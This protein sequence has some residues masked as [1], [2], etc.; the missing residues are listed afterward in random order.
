MGV[1]PSAG[2]ILSPDHAAALPP[3]PA[4]DALLKARLK[5][6]SAKAHKR[7]KDTTEEDRE[8]TVCQ[9]E[10]PFYVNTVKL[11][12]DRCARMHAVAVGVAGGTRAAAA[13]DSIV[14]T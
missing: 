4:Q 14:V 11:F 7:V 5:L 8:A 2:G 3:G 13:A 1:N 10:N 9:R 6:Y 12:R